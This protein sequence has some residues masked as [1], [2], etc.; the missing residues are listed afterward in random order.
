MPVSFGPGMPG[1]YKAAYS[2]AIYFS[3]APSLPYSCGYRIKLRL[4][5]LVF[6]DRCA[7]SVSLH[8]PQAA[9][10]SVA[11]QPSQSLSNRTAF[12][13]SSG[14]RRWATCIIRAHSIRL[15][16]TLQPYS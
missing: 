5:R 10:D 6:C 7:S 8:P 15:R 14:S 13:A 3:H 12:F 1:P 16:N 9:L 2:M 4:Y 11:P